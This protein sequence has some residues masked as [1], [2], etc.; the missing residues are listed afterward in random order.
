L[1][2]GNLRL[3][4]L[5]AL[6]RIPGATIWTVETGAFRPRVGE[7]RVDDACVRNIRHKLVRRYSRQPSHVS[8]QSVVGSALNLK[9]VPK[10]L[11]IWCQTGK[12]ALLVDAVLRWDEA[13]SVFE[14]DLRKKR[15]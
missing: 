15:E 5:D 2:I 4:C 14:G 1:V 11:A 3:R 8:N 12:H 6:C 9:A 7:C 10:N 13:F